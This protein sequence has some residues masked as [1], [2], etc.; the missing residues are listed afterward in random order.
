MQLLVIEQLSTYVSN[1][2]ANMD[3]DTAL[4]IIKALSFHNNETHNH[5]ITPTK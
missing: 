2:L 4:I 5:P 3:I 1:P